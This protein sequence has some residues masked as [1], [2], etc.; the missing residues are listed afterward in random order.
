MAQIIFVLLMVHDFFCQ[1]DEK[2][3]GGRLSSK[4]A[5]PET[6]GVNILILQL[7][8]DSQNKVCVGVCF[9]AKQAIKK[10]RKEKK[11]R[12]RKLGLPEQDLASG[13]SGSGG[14]HGSGGYSG[15]GGI[16]EY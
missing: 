3:K 16:L 8:Q 11:E 14:Y 9:L 7:H 15:G 5:R 12:R 10:R 2:S 1:K 13:G 4:I 6:A